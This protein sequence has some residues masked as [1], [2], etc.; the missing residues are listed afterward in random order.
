M[1]RFYILLDGEVTEERSKECIQRHMAPHHVEFLNTEWFSTYNGTSASFIVPL[2]FGLVILSFNLYPVLMICS[3]SPRTSRKHIHLARAPT[4]LPC[5]RCCPCTCCKWR[6][7][8]EYRDR[9][10]FRPHV[11]C[12]PCLQWLRQEPTPNLR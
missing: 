2:H 1:A 4:Y 3:R 5:W 8:L 10:L 6:S 11:A 12:L 7:R 9:R